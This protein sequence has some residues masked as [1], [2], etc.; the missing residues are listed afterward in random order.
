MRKKLVIMSV[1]TL[2][3]FLIFSDLRG[4]DNQERLVYQIIKEAGNKGIWI[5]DIRRGCG[6]APP[7]LNKILKKLEN[8]KVIKAIKSVG[9]SLPGLHNYIKKL[10]FQHLPSIK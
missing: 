7:P 5:R 3:T 4:S 9:V 1:H 2:N 10:I 8:R 6:L